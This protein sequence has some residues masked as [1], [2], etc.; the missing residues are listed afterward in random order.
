M[1][2]S[3][4]P[5]Q[6]HMSYLNAFYVTWT[7][8]CNQYSPHLPISTEHVDCYAIHRLQDFNF[9]ENPTETGSRIAVCLSRTRK[10]VSM[11][12][13][14]T[15]CLNSKLFYPGWRVKNTFVYLYITL[16]L[17]YAKDILERIVQQFI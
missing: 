17:P 11:L 14:Q 3:C 9:L 6:H 7:I 4:L 15:L 5:L 1:D 12:W 13:L 16:F 10:Y 2:A 8:S